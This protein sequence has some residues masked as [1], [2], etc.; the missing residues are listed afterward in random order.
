M[1]IFVGSFGKCRPLYLEREDPEVGPGSDSRTHQF[2]Q[3]LP[4]LLADLRDPF[5][6]QVSPPTILDFLSQIAQ[7]CAA[8]WP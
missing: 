1:P 5:L 6:G 2:C 7:S 4:Q 8:A 3:Q